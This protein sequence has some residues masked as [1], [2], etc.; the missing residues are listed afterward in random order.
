LLFDKKLA[1]RNGSKSE[2]FELFPAGADKKKEKVVS[3]KQ[4]GYSHAITFIFKKPEKHR[5]LL[6][7]FHK[8][9]PL[10]SFIDKPFRKLKLFQNNFMGNLYLFL[11]EKLSKY[12]GLTSLGQV[13]M[14]IMKSNKILRFF[15]KNET[16]L[17]IFKRI[18]GTKL[19]VVGRCRTFFFTRFFF[20]NPILEQRVL[21]LLGAKLGKWL[22]LLYN[23]KGSVG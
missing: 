23:Q 1:N 6:K 13:S 16:F 8:K 17:K 2:I 7:I 20:S 11:K 18:G 10:F 14:S 15:L 21:S 12:I 19:V 22:K 9:F 5:F 3:F 4:L